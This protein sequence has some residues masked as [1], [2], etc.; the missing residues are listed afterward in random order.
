M[1]RRLEGKIPDDLLSDVAALVSWRDFLA[2]RYLRVR[3][4]AESAT[5]ARPTFAMPAELFELGRAFTEV[6]QRVT[7]QT[8][9]VLDSWPARA[10]DTPDEVRAAFE[11]AARAF[12]TAQP[13][14]FSRV[15]NRAMPEAQDP[16]AAEK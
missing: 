4:F 13:P 16:A 14:Q 7:E 6:T 10:R 8:F 11:Q 15:P 3:L 1:R 5:E 9:A 2:H 12:I